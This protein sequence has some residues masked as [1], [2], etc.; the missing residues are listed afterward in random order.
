MLKSLKFVLRVCDSVLL[1]IYT[2]I[3]SIFKFYIILFLNCIFCY[4]FLNRLNWKKW[5][6]EKYIN[7][8][9][10]SFLNL[11]KSFKSSSPQE[12]GTITIQSL[13]PSSPACTDQCLLT[14]ETLSTDLISL[15][16]NQTASVSFLKGDEF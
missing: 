9:G 13:G 5:Q 16:S 10:N 4:S 8:F 1:P 12:A 11:K 7:S 6:K 2:F 15:Y 3:V 14:W